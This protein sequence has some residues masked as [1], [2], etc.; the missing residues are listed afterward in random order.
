MGPATDTRS[1]GRGGRWWGTVGDRWQRTGLGTRGCRQGLGNKRR[2][3]HF[4]G[5]LVSEPPSAQIMRYRGL[6]LSP[7]LWEGPWVQRAGRQSLKLLNSGGSQ[8]G[9][10]T[11]LRHPSQG[12]PRCSGGPQ[13]QEETHGTPR[14][15]HSAASPPHM[16]SA[17]PSAPRALG[18]H[19]KQLIARERSHQ[20][21]NK[22]NLT[23]GMIIDL[24]KKGKKRKIEL[25][26]IFEGKLEFNIITLRD[27]TDYNYHVSEVGF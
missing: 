2:A 1:R 11:E 13:S 24:V 18:L 21:L 23:E 14:S 19:F 25:E 26:C 20:R 6:I 22:H 9:P 8:G 7:G 3:G 12:T 5:V 16:A 15:R 4:P 17:G 10:G 27:E